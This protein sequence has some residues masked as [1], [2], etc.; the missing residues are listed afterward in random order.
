MKTK[1]QLVS[2]AFDEL[3]INGITSSAD[4]EDNVLALQSLEQLVSEL[5]IDIGWRFEDQPDPN[6]MSGIPQYAESA[7]YMALAVRIAPRYGKDAGLIRTQASAAMSALVARVNKPRQVSY[8]TRMPMGLGNRRQYPYSQQ[9][10]PAPD[11]APNSINTEVFSVGDSRPIVLD[12]TDF[13][14]PEESISS[15]T[16]N[17]TGGLVVT[18]DEPVGATILLTVTAR[19]FGYQLIMITANGDADTVVNRRIDFQV[20]DPSAIRGNP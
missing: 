10:M 1:I 11:I 14:L 8:P 9:F 18:N 12:F 4:S 6:T 17:V 7:I 3:R 20:S 5:N 19:D 15:Y 13:L 2:M 16:L